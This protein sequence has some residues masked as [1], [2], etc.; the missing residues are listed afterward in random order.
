[1]DAECS[2][3]PWLLE[4]DLA[5]RLVV[6]TVAVAVVVV[7]GRFRSRRRPAPLNVKGNFESPGVHL[8]TSET[9]DSC[10]VARRRYRQVLGEHGFVEHSWEDE[11]ALLER[12]GV[13]EIP[14]GTVI[15]EGGSEIASFRLVPNV[16]ALRRAAARLR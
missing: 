11:P 16:R 12:L 9:C 1:M 14:V 10:D 15:G 2:A 13:E 7:V 3:E 6:V 4:A 8:F 5:A